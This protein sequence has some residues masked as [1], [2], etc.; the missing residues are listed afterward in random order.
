MGKQWKQCQTLFFWAPKSLQMVTAAMKLKDT[1][2]LE[3]KL[4]PTLCEVAQSCLTLCNPM[5]CSLP[6]SFIHGV[7]Q[8]RV[9]EWVAISFSRESSQPRI[10]TR[11]SCIAGRFFTDWAMKEA[12]S[13]CLSTCYPHVLSLL[14][15]T[16]ITWLRYYLSALS[17]VMY[18]Y[19]FCLY[20]TL[21]KKI[22]MHRLHLRNGD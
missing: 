18:S 12:H 2:F 22:T 21:W 8:A 4:W 5:D 1:C 9:L 7:F 19:P 16:L 20:Y 3:E 15:L 14:M 6:G 17:T 10:W 11:V 13:L